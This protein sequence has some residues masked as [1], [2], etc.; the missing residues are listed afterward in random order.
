MAEEILKGR[1]IYQKRKTFLLPP[2]FRFGVIFPKDE[3][4]EEKEDNGRG[5]ESPVKN[6]KKGKGKEKKGKESEGRRK[7]SL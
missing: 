2:A 4:K 6:K 5:K 3:G 1:L 7:V